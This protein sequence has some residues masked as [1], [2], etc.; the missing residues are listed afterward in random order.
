MLLGYSV[1]Y[2]G[3]QFYIEKRK[4]ALGTSKR[5]I[6]KINI[7]GAYNAK[8][9]KYLF[10]ADTLKNNPDNFIVVIVTS[11]RRWGR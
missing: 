6:I 2:S 5:L 10:E 9:C 11:L 1:N 4:I 7:R 3:I 8:C